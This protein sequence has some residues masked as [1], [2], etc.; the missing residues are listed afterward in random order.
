MRAEKEGAGEIISDNEVKGFD[1]MSTLEH[2]VTSRNFLLTGFVFPCMGTSISITPLASLPSCS[3]GVQLHL[4]F[5][6]YEASFLIF[7]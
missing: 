4:S 5:I 1:D 6:L 3:W 7:S 2:R